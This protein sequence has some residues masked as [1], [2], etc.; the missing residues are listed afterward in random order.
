MSFRE[1]SFVRVAQFTR[2]VNDSSRK[3]RDWEPAAQ[4]NMRRSLACAAGS[5]RF[6][7]S[8]ETQ[9]FRLPIRCLRVHSAQ[10]LGHLA[11]SSFLPR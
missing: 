4:G 10:F 3:L 11:R 6:Y 7:C 2:S 9:L 1:T 5:N 8:I